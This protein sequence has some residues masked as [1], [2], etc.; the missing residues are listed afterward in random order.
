MKLVQHGFTLLELII[1]LSI[2][3]I[4]ASVAVPSFDKMI[5]SNKVVSIAEQLY[6]NILYAQSEA[7]RRNS[8]I[9]LDLTGTGTSTWSYEIQ[10]CSSTPCEVLKSFDST[11][12]SGDITIAYTAG[13]DGAIFES[14]RGFINNQGDISF[15]Y[16]T[17]SDATIS[18]NVLGRPSICSNT[19]GNYSNC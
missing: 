12:E 11:N 15:T 16:G 5:N 14:D 10:D 1:T 3:A 8:N 13:L 2:V 6:Q 9:T 18:I 17:S 7:I 4:V 19:L